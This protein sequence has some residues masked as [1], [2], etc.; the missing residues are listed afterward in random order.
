MGFLI[1]ELFDLYLNVIP[2][3]RMILNTGYIS[4]ANS[5]F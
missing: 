3:F 2:Q 4:E 1:P 5:N